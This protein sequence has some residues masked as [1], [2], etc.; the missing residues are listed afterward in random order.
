MRRILAPLALALVTVLPATAQTST[1]FIKIDIVSK[2]LMGH[3]HEKNSDDPTEV[4]VRLP[5]SLAK[6]LLETVSDQ[7]FCIHG[8]VDT[9]N[10]TKKVNK[11]QKLKADQLLKL[12]ESAH[13]GDLLLEVTTDKGDHVKVA[14]E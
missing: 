13:A 2:S 14:V 3:H 6:G 7:E 4:H 11:K 12:L 9:D 8:S 5:L 1:R 10:G